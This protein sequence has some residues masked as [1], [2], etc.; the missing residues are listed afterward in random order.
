MEEAMSEHVGPWQVLPGMTYS[1]AV[2][3]KLVRKNQAWSGGQETLLTPRGHIKRFHDK[4]KAEQEATKRN[5]GVDSVDGG[6]TNG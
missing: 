5:A 4:A 6:K 1:G 2:F 3:H